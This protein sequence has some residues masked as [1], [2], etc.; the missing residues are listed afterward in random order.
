[1]V[2]RMARSLR[3]GMRKPLFRPCLYGRAD[4]GGSLVHLAKPLTYMNRSGEVLPYLLR[5]TGTPPGGLVVVCD[6]MDL[7]TGRLRLKTRGGSAGHRGLQ[8]IIAA[9]GTEDFPRLYLGIG[10]PPPGVEVVS[11]VL[12]P[13]GPEEEG[14]IM[15][16][17]ERAAEA[18][19]RLTGEKPE[20]VMHAI[21]GS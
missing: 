21:N 4:C 7:P 8:S 9:L 20:T 10:R 14:E 15:G 19:L 13:F 18:L 5:R 17:V 11:H 1:M 3:V 16:A 12:G 6:T 2:D